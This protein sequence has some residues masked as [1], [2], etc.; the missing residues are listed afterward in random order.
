MKIWLVTIYEP[1]PFGA[2]QTRPQRCG[3][4]AKAL[5]GRGHK[6]ELW[7]STFEHVKHTHYFQKSSRQVISD[8]FSIQY[9]DGC[10]YKNDYSPKRFFH[11]RQTARNFLEIALERSSPPDIIF[12]PVPSLEMAE[13]ATNYAKIKSCPI[14]V[15]IRDLWPDV[16]FTMF[17]E[18]MRSFVKP[19][20]YS[21]ILRA[22]RILRGANAIT[23]ISESYLKWGLDYAERNARHSDQVFHLGFANDINFKP[24]DIDSLSWSIRKKYDIGI[25]KFIVTYVGTFSDFYDIPCILESARLFLDDERVH[26]LIVGSGEKANKLFS[27]GKQLKNVTMT[28][29]VDFR[30]V[31]AL[32][33]I[34]DVGLVAYSDIAT[35]SLPNKPFEYMASGIP[36]LSSLK[37]E[38]ESMILNNNI[39]RMYKSGDVSS[40]VSEIKWFLNNRDAAKVMGIKALSLFKREFLGE[41]VYSKLAIHLERISV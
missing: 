6:V 36:L 1:L 41:V 10:G 3:M 11:N 27:I 32:L 9:L 24:N 33:G 13:A 14:V 25:N 4:L 26:F 35:M 7:T 34:T 12:A 28:G 21:E 40:L 16:Y 39:G 2:P 37:G 19:F 17:P 38:M 5:I 31:C 22:R 29:W 8:N 20:F 15:D 18:F 30:E 23:A